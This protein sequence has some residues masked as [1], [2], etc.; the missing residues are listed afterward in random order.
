M[1][2]T[3]PTARQSQTRLLGYARRAVSWLLILATVTTVVALS[4]RERRL[5]VDIATVTRA[6]MD[7]RVEE[8]GQT[9]IREKYVVS[10]PLAARLS[11]ITLKVGDVVNKDVTVLS[12]L[13]ATDPSLLDPRAV[14]QATA[15][16]RGAERKLDLA[17]SSLAKAEAKLQFAE[18]ETGRVR[19]MVVGNAASQSQLESQESLFRMLGEEVRGLG[20][21][22]DIAQYE[23]ELEK[24]ALLLTRSDPDDQVEMTLAIQAPIDGR[25]L[26]IYQEST[27]VVRAGEPLLEIG[28]PKDLEII[29]DVLSRDAVRISPGDAVEL[30]H[31][32]GDYTLTGRVRLVE[33]SG[34]TK[35][36]AL[37]VEEQRVN[38][39]IDLENPPEERLQL[40]DGF[41]VDC[42]V[43]VWR[44]ADVLQIPT[45]AMFRVEGAWHVFA[46][47]DGIAKRTPIVVGQNNGRMAQIIEGLEEGMPVIVHPSDKLDDG[48]PI[49]KR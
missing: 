47:T 36:S 14:A 32:G 33:P 48:S 15:R 8:D 30:K 3:Q 46:I 23:L 21:A 18:S 5:L 27:A 37:G 11:R 1:N 49:E 7:V 31:W 6:T 19:K 45:S 9:R 39:I 43:V 44:Q 2:K 16:V 17:R 24:A 12:R 38:V 34:F 28:D 20:F 26:R 22:V 41:R 35:T 4:F 10:T 40:G 13:E 29:A 25:I 42:E